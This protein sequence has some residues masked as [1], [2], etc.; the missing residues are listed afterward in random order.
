MSASRRVGLP[1][2]NLNGLE[3]S[4]SGSVTSYLRVSSAVGG[5]RQKKEPW[6]SIG[7]GSLDIVLDFSSKLVLDFPK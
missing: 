5:A 1:G 4:S 7:E 6:Y 2:L 3:K